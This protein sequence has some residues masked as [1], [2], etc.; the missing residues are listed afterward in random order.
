M[1]SAATLLKS[2]RLL[3]TRACSMMA[4]K[5]SKRGLPDDEVHHQDGE[6]ATS[7]ARCRDEVEV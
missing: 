5:M 7:V 6:G 3:R 4:A 1:N 2:E